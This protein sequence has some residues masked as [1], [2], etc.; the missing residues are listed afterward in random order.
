MKPRAF[1]GPAVL[2]KNNS[3]YHY[4]I[5]LYNIYLIKPNNFLSTYYNL[6]E[7]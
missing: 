4:S 7:V 6:A 3:M 1:I 5:R 2:I